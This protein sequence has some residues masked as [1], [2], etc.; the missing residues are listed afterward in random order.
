M[1][2]CLGGHITKMLSFLLYCVSSWS[3][4][5]Q[6]NNKTFSSEVLKRRPNEV[7]VTLWLPHNSSN[8]TDMYKLVL[9]NASKLSTPVIKFGIIDAE[10]NYN[11]SISEG[12]KT[13]PTLLIYYPDGKIVYKNKVSPARLV[14]VATK[15]LPDLTQQINESWVDT[16]LTKP[17]AMLFSDKSTIP[18]V[19]K[20]IAIHYTNKL[21][22]GFTN[23]SDLFQRF[24]VSYA[25]TILFNN[26]THVK[27]INSSSYEKIISNVESFFAKQFLKLDGIQNTSLL[28]MNQFRE[29]CLGAKHLCVLVKSS[30]PSNLV[31]SLKKRNSKSKML[32]LIGEKYFPI[33]EM[34]DKEGVWV[35]NPR[36]DAY[37]HSA[38]DKL[39]SLFEDITN[40]AVRWTKRK[41]NSQEL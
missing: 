35:Y 10:A 17:S 19:W 39:E 3:P 8:I 20:S 33:D 30:E 16:F 12:V 37:I 4:L 9:N 5:H 24:G 41:Q 34:K 38:E 14:S 22:V 23:N 27:T 28:P 1:L 11:T 40:G 36:K 31:N 15:L 32:W 18:M 21:R 25:P 26:G 13:V 7:W 6:L 29:K 2:Q